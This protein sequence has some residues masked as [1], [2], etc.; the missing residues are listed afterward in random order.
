M[1]ALLKDTALNELTGRM[2]KSA[3]DAVGRPDG[4]RFHSAWT[5]KPETRIEPAGPRWGVDC[6]LPARSYA[7]QSPVFGSRQENAFSNRTD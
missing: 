1:H 7:N 6:S 4:R 3:Q 5:Y 2:L